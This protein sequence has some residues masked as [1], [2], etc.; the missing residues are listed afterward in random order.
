MATDMAIFT[1]IREMAEALLAAVEAD[2]AVMPQ[3]LAAVAM[4]LVITAKAA[5]G[6]KTALMASA[7]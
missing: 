1:L 4:E 2:T 5:I 7:L 3:V 6:A